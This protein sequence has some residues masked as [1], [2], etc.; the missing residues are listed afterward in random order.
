MSNM[1]YSLEICLP[2][3]KNLNP[4]QT[5]C[6]CFTWL[7]IFWHCHSSAKRLDVKFCSHWSEVINKHW[8]NCQQCQLGIISKV[9]PQYYLQ[10]FDFGR[11]STTRLFSSCDF[12]YKQKK[13]KVSTNSTGN[14][15]KWQV[16]TSIFV[17]TCHHKCYKKGSK[18]IK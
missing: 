7:F 14:L 10:Q 8:Q 3:I 9:N 17:C 6:L 11:T 12:L 2:Q 5:L 4:N 18:S 16:L 1:E 13:I 15:K